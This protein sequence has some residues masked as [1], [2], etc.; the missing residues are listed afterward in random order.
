[1]NLKE[2][3]K[4]GER[5]YGTMVRM[6]RN[7]AFCI[8]AK[9]CGLDFV[10]FDCEHAA[11]NL[12]T[13]HDLFQMAHALDLTALLR[14]PMLDK[15]SISRSL[16]AG[17]K[18]VMVP[19]TE[20]PEQAKEIVRWS[21][22]APIGDRGFCSGVGSMYYRPQPDLSA[23]MEEINSQVLS[24]A[25]IET[26]L[27]IENVEAIAATEGIDALIVGPND[28]SISLGIPGK[29]LDPMEYTAIRRVADACKANGKAF[30]IHGPDS[31]QVLFAKDINLCISSTDID[32]MRAGIRGLKDKL[33]RFASEAER[34]PS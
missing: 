9:E 26:A 25:Q 31:L 11:Y 1:M 13:L 6:E 32:L 33:V 30:G 17:A 8:V 12:E 34:R 29:L 21:K 10:M 18:G 4:A 16:D 23:A 28:L 14:V 15:E 3:L 20:T 22:Y 24:I 2:R 7:P 19:M 5:V 27:A